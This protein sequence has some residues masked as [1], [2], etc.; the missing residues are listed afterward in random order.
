ML[1]IGE[2]WRL[3]ALAK[4]LFAGPHMATTD[5]RFDYGEVQQIAL[6]PIGA[7]ILA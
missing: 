4:I 5:D 7:S 1:S 2:T 3:P 6:G